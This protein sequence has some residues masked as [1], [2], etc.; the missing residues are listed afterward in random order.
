MA[1][2]QKSYRLPLFSDRSRLNALTDIRS[3]QLLSHLIII[4]AQ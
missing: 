3:T 1:A 2:N 4:K